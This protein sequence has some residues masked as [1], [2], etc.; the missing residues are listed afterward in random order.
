M[1]SLDLQELEY[2]IN[3]LYHEKMEIRQKRADLRSSNPNCMVMME[4]LDSQE[5]EID[6][7]INKII[8]HIKRIERF[9]TQEMMRD[10]EISSLLE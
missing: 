10:Q 1:D 9:R 8:R 5:S 4:G 6:E 3:E 2:R 7:G